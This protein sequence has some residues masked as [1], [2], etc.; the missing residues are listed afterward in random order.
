MASLHAATAIGRWLAPIMNTGIWTTGV[1]SIYLQ[2]PKAENAVSV[3]I[4][5]ISYLSVKCQAYVISFML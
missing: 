1:C 5:Y 4:R 3:Y 2:G